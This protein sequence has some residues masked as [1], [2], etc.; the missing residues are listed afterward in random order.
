MFNINTSIANAKSLVKIGIDPGHGGYDPGVVL[1]GIIEKKLTLDISKRLEHYLGHFGYNVTMTRKTD[2]ALYQLSKK[3]TSFKTRDLKARA[4]IINN[5][6]VK[7]FASI[8]VNSDVYSKNSTGSI[9]YYYSK[10]SKSKALAD[11]IQN[12]LNNITINNRKR[13][14]HKSRPAD[15]YI[16]KKTS[17]PGVLVETAFI[18]NKGE[19]KLLKSENFKN[20]IALAIANGIKNSKMQQDIIIKRT[21]LNKTIKKSIRKPTLKVV[22]SH[23]KI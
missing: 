18:S 7:L 20:K 22:H 5:S 9:V 11:S 10:S 15:F 16:L 8:H 6:G 2:I 23:K 17:A 14:Q 21:D 3:G 1:K 13:Q 4:N 12:S 19:R